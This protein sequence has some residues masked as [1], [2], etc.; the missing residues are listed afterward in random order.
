MK[1]K[2]FLKLFYFIEG[3]GLRT[4]TAEMVMHKKKP[5]SPIFEGDG[6][7]LFVENNNLKLHL[8]NEKYKGRMLRR[9]LRDFI[10][11]KKGTPRTL[12]FWISSFG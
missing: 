1:P 2:K 6:L 5:K 9:F 8:K 7:A 3:A 10:H 12:N 11:F 4:A